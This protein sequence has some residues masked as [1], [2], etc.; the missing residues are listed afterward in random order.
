MDKQFVLPGKMRDALIS[1]LRTM[2]MEQ[3]EE[4][5]T[6]LRSL[7]PLNEPPAPPVLDT[8]A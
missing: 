2:P 5:V 3:V 7:K 6:L 1:F 4:P 8:P